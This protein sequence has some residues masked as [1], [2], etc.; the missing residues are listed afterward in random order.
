MFFKWNTFHGSTTHKICES[1]FVNSAITC[2]VH[3]FHIVHIY[4]RSSNTSIQADTP[5]LSIKYCPF[6]FNSYWRLYFALSNY[7]E[8]LSVWRLD[9][10]CLNAFSCMQS[11]S[12]RKRR[13]KVITLLDMLVNRGLHCCSND[14]AVI[15]T[16]LRLLQFRSKRQ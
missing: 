7:V 13:K 14:S 1:S 10:I 8:R 15:Y 2:S 12:I 11:Q 9:Y 6:N 16:L 5:Y 4:K 3:I